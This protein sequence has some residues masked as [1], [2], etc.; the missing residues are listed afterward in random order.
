MLKSTTLETELSAE[1]IN[2]RLKTLIKNPILMENISSEHL[3]KFDAFHGKFSKYGFLLVADKYDSALKPIIK[4]TL[5]EIYSGT[6][7]GLKLL[8][9]E[10]NIL[11]FSIT[12][13]M[14]I[15][16]VIINIFGLGFIDAC[17][18]TSLN[19]ALAEPR[20]TNLLLYFSVLV[21]VVFGLIY[22]IIGF[23]YFEVYIKFK[24]ILI[25][26]LEAKEI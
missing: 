11:S 25:S 9:S 6:E 24:N 3:N 26:M 1:E 8:I 23:R 12:V 21:I 17:L 13:L 18:G 7:I 15:T 14:L 19:M 2:L 20:T 10:R 22:S 16:L 5:R 4:G